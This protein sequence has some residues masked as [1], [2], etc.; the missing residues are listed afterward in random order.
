MKHCGL[1]NL[2]QKSAVATQQRSPLFLKEKGGAGERENFF[3]REKKFSLSPVHAFTLIELLVVI[4]IIA[5]LA[6]ILLPAL[7]QA[8]SRAHTAS[9]VNQ[10]KQIATI[11][12]S[13]ID[14]FDGY[15][16]Y[17]STAADNAHYKLYKFNEGVVPAAGGSS[18]FLCP[19]DTVSQD[20]WSGHNSYGVNADVIRK[21]AKISLIYKTSC[22]MWADAYFWRFMYYD[23]GSDSE[24]YLRY[25]HG[26]ASAPE[27]QW[28]YS[29]GSE[30]NSARFDGSVRGNTERIT[31]D[32]KSTLTDAYL[33]TNWMYMKADLTIPYEH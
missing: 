25:R 29:T 13:Y 3:S 14:A 26:K 15:L 23:H 6:A 2:A 9:C 33:G 16:P 11:S 17:Y 28:Q 1:V 19:S 8:R 18:F 20:T 30:I 7:N 5:I 22:I 12:L 24:H 32:Y 10:L 4:A 31:K 27:L 21:G